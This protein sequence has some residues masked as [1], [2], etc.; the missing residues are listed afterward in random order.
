MPATLDDAIEQLQ[1]ATEATT[2]LTQ[3]VVV[4]KQVL[5]DAVDDAA[6]SA[7]TA[8]TAAEAAQGVGTAVETARAIVVAAR[9]VT[10]GARD[11]TKAARDDTKVSQAAAEAAKTQ[12]GVLVGQAAAI[13]EATA[14]IG[15]QVAAAA[16]VPALRVQSNI[17]TPTVPPSGVASG[18][19]YW[20]T[21]GDR[22][23][24]FLNTNGTGA[25]VFPNVDAPLSSALNTL[26]YERSG[27]SDAVVDEDFALIDGTSQ[28]GG[29]FVEGVRVSKLSTDLYGGLAGKASIAQGLK[30]DT[31]VQ[32]VDI[33]LYGAQ[34]EY[35]RSGYT[36][37]LLDEDLRVLEGTDAMGVRYIEGM[38]LSTAVSDLSNLVGLYS[39]RFEFERSGYIDVL[40]DEDFRIL[41]GTTNTG[42][43]IADG[44]RPAKSSVQEAPLDG[45]SY[46]RAS[47]AWTLLAGAAR[48]PYILIA[49]FDAPDY[50]KGMADYVCGGVDDYPLIQGVIDNLPVLPLRIVTGCRIT[51]ARG[52]HVMLSEGTFNLSQ[53]LT[54]A[55][56]SVVHFH[57]SGLSADR[58]DRLPGESST[59]TGIPKGDGGT[60]LYFTSPSGRALYWPRGVWPRDNDP[61]VTNEV[62]VSGIYAGGF[63]VYVKNPSVQSGVAMID[64]IGMATGRVQDIYAIGLPRSPSG[65]HKCTYGFTFTG[66]ARSDMKEVI[67]CAASGVAQNCF[68]SD[69]THI[70]FDRCSANTV[71]G[72]TSATASGFAIRPDNGVSLGYVH[73]FGTGQGIRTTGS[74][75]LHCEHADFEAL[76]TP[77]LLA[78]KSTPMHFSHVS[79][80]QADTIWVGDLADYCIV[81]SAYRIGGAVRA[82]GSITIPAGQ[83]TA[84]ADLAMCGT[85]RRPPL[86]IPNSR[87][88]VGAWGS[89]TKTQ[90]IANIAAPAAVETTLS[91]EVRCA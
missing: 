36:E 68:V 46:A 14:V 11:E 86:L 67:H 32:P 91:Y 22:L 80:E 78:D 15:D 81:D 30:A 87:E 83:T 54:F 44:V 38:R 45:R 63:H 88:G 89:A 31:A 79:S 19:Q 71:S 27:Y 10:T 77:V 75:Q 62:P 37:A 18:E 59:S 8:S 85:P 12:T 43:F 60:V 49:A 35:E 74:G 7:N 3:V 70:H 26:E 76:N 17:A 90:V 13:K 48:A 20:A 33:G 50:I 21:F 53:E 65:G 55:S 24:L 1:L 73:C 51:G 2:G 61:T 52:G 84:A 16:A 64:C 29:R 5:D 57:G 42:A 4:R 9:D 28:A 39:N 23:R 47:G 72:G 56:G 25:A 40:F 82:T 58:Y 69:T 6:S 34:Y 41:E 66:G